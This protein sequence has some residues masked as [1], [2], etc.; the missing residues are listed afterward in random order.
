MLS[1]PSREN[2]LTS[3]VAVGPGAEEKPHDKPMKLET[4]RQPVAA[5]NNNSSS[6]NNSN[7]SSNNSHNNSNR[8]PAEEVRDG[9][10]RR[11]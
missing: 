9:D 3:D 6:N 10:R 8:H 11:F 1:F 7:S 5:N 4:R 2:H